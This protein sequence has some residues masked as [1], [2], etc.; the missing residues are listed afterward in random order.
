MMLSKS[1]TDE[2]TNIVSWLKMVIYK[3]NISENYHMVGAL[4][5]EKP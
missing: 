3:A 2:V 5:I 4:F 1:G